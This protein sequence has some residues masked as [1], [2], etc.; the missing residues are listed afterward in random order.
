MVGS[1]YTQK[2]DD[3]LQSLNMAPVSS[4]PAM[5]SEVLLVLQIFLNSPSA[6]SQRKLSASKEFLE[7]LD[8]AHLE[9]ALTFL[10]HSFLE[11]PSCY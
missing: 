5:V 3:A 6:S 7:Q 9:T 4:K 8:Q 10:I 1:R 2:F 11:W